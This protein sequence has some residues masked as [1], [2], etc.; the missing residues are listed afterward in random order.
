M[1]LAENSIVLFM[2]S[3]ATT[4]HDIAYHTS[5]IPD[6]PGLGS[7]IRPVY[8]L[9]NI[10]LIGYRGTGKTVVGKALSRRLERPFYDADAYLEEKLGRTIRDMVAGQ[11]WPFFRA[12]E[13]EVIRE[14]AAKDDC[15]IATGG[16]AVMDKDNVARLRDKGTFVLLKADMDTMI[17]RIL[18]DE[19]SPQQR[20][21]LSEGDIYEET[22]R[23][24][25]Q[26]MPIYE[27]VA[28]F[29]VDTSNLTID[30]VVDQIV[31]YLQAE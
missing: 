13:K 7:R 17:R 18:G 9:M 6:T 4:N 16:G 31:R 14:I 10:V 1:N 30:G 22:E 27:D 2:Q 11:G 5:H 15:V 23:L 21:K 8:D 12:R 25:R 24:L 20:P 28:D 19:S 3:E 26:R 29:S